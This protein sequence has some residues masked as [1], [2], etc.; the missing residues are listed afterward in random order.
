M[1]LKITKVLVD[2]LD[3]SS[4]AHTTTLTVDGITWEVDL[5]ADNHDKLMAA[6]EPFTS[7]GR[8]VG[9]R[10]PSRR[11]AASG[12]RTAQIREW[13]AANGKKVADRGRI[14]ADVVAAYEAAH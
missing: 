7:A 14:P 3:G 11:P 2:D 10:R 5:S 4:A 9:G 13:A 1:A 12:S 8:K 6:L